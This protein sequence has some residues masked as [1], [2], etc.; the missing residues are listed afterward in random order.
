MMRLKALSAPELQQTQG[1]AT[2]ARQ[3]R[4]AQFD[5]TTEALLYA[6]YEF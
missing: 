4:P 3:S 6:H 5:Y 1:W 2:N